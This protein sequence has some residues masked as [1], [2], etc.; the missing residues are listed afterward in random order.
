MVYANIRTEF[1]QGLK[2][3]Q[4]DLLQMG[5][6]VNTAIKRS[7]DALTN[8]DEKLARQVVAD[9]AQI[10]DLRFKIETDCIALIAKQQPVA[11]DLRTIVAVMNITL[12]LERIGDHAAGVAKIAAEMSNQPPFKPP[13]NLPLMAD[14]CRDMLMQSLNAFVARDNGWT[15]KIMERDDEVDD[16]YTQ[17]FR[18][19]LNIM[20]EDPQ[21]VT[22]AM[23]LLFAAHN[24]ERIADRVTN[25]CERSLFRTTGQLEEMPSHPSVISVEGLP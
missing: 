16:L 1:T 4:D 25:I 11:T 13:I 12:E 7:M 2:N 5:S 14:T 19:L 18:K 21:T 22:Q 3:L 17:I 23:Y 15:E 6:M 24:M 20:L 9:D 8:R 10:N